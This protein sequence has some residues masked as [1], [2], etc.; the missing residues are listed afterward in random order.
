MVASADAMFRGRVQKVD[1]KA[2][3]A[4]GDFCLDVTAF[5]A[6][7]K[8]GWPK[9]AHRRPALGRKQSSGRVA[10]VAAAEHGL[11]SA[12]AKAAEDELVLRTRDPEQ[13]AAILRA[14]RREA[15]AKKRSA[16]PGRKAVPA[17][18]SKRKNGEFLP[19]KYCV[20][21]EGGVA[22]EDLTTWTAEPSGV[23]TFELADPGKVLVCAVSLDGGAKSDFATKYFELEALPAL[24][25]AKH[26][27][28]LKALDPGAW[29]GGACAVCCAPVV[30]AEAPYCS[31]A[32]QK[33][34]WKAAHKKLCKQIANAGGALQFDA[35]AKAK[36][37]ADAAIAECAGGELA[38]VDEPC[39]I[40]G[41]DDRAGL[42][43]G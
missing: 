22:P 25:S 12:A 4:C 39:Y 8:C 16:A 18:T 13:I 1:K 24:V 7:C 9:Q 15:A 26:E 5:G 6:V 14:R 36:V 41:D 19:L 30:A 43:R 17:P 23:A 32:C 20:V 31:A 42:V 21:A 3:K 38:D 2:A 11:R 34:D 40:C 27:H 33:T 10:A 35:D 37:A 28:V 29:R